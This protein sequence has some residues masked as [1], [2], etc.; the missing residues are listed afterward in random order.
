[1]LRKEDSEHQVHVH[2]REE[3]N[4]MLA[5]SDQ[6]LEL[7][8]RWDEEE[9][10]AE[11]AAKAAGVWRPPLMT[12]EE[13][14]AWVTQGPPP[15]EREV[16]VVHG[17]RGLLGGCASRAWTLAWALLAGL[18][19]VH[20]IIPQHTPLCVTTTNPDASPCTPTHPTPWVTHPHDGN[21]RTACQKRA[22]PGARAAV[23]PGG[24]G[25]TRRYLR[26][27][28]LTGW[29]GAAGTC[30]SQ[31]RSRNQCGRGRM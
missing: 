23:L 13:V 22:A 4:K 17:V 6:E 25:A 8:D 7:F 20:N 10:G 3:V 5:R 18:I 2:T 14:P 9:A 19:T 12:A 31:R 28:S 26:R 11:E 1:M 30:Q 27:S 24:Q 21:R 15:E 29:R 16:S